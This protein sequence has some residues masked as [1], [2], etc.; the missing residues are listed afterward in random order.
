MVDMPCEGEQVFWFLLGLKG[1]F[2]MGFK[3]S[4]FDSK[5]KLAIVTLH[6]M[7]ISRV[8][9]EAFSHTIYQVM[10]SIQDPELFADMEQICCSPLGVI[11]DYSLLVLG[12]PC[13]F[14]LYN[15]QPWDVQPRD[16][17]LGHHRPEFWSMA[18]GHE[19]F[20]V[21][22]LREKKYLGFIRVFI[23]ILE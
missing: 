22:C 19:S 15:F 23:F 12:I 3:V 11:R 16:L 1:C 18:L 6:A 14:W 5:F 9:P 2:P 13:R 8:H 21:L 17:N 4:P 20:R 10:M 7:R